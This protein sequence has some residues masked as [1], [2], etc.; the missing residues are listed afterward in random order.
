MKSIKFPGCNLEI[1]KGQPEYNVIHA[2]Q[3]PGPEG[4]IIACYELT[5]EEIEQILRTRKIYYS[6]LTFHQKFQPM[7]LFTELSDGVELIPE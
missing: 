4:E 6:R 1:G 5:D 2:M 7:R 3:M